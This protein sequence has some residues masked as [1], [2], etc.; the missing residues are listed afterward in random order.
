MS[1]KNND[2]FIK[3]KCISRWR[4]GHTPVCG[5]DDPTRRAGY[6]PLGVIGPSLI[7]F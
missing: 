5:N 4:L 1:L 7:G 2:L 3:S 6:V